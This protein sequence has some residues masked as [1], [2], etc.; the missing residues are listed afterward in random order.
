[1]KTEILRA[2]AIIRKLQKAGF[3]FFV[4]T[5]P[6]R[7]E[8]LHHSRFLRIHL[9]SHIDNPFKPPASAQ[10][11]IHPSSSTPLVR[12]FFPETDPGEPAATLAHA[13][14]IERLKNRLAR[15]RASF[16]M[17]ILPP[18]HSPSPPTREI[19]PCPTLSSRTICG[20]RL[21]LR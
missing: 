5:Q 12:Q 4:S 11:D 16:R 15:H 9:P 10:I 17:R 14:A 21:L 19:R 7:S 3:H 2:A 13:L 18:H 20:S 6:N 1:M 8:P